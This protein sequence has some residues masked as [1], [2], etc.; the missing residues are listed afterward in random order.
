M[1][2]DGLYENWCRTAY[3]LI[4]QQLYLT[5]GKFGCDVAFSFHIFPANSNLV[6]VITRPIGLMMRI[7]AGIAHGTHP[8]MPNSIGAKKRVF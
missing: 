6:F 5:T 4:R 7:I 1:L 2:Q 8:A 3:S